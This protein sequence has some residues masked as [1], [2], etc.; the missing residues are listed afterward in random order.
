METSLVLSM[1]GAEMMAWATCVQWMKR[2]SSSHT[3]TLW[4]CSRQFD[5]RRSSWGFFR[6]SPMRW[7]H[8]VFF[9]YDYHEQPC[10]FE[11]CSLCNLLS[12][13]KHRKMNLGRHQHQQVRIWNFS[14]GRRIVT[15][16]KRMIPWMYLP[17]VL[18]IRPSMK[19]LGL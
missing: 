15:N 9:K 19:M 8:I 4:F 12:F 13:H 16:N 6:L 1:K 18:L 17:S 7:K 3:Q 10:A 5:P 14:F 2:K 11:Q